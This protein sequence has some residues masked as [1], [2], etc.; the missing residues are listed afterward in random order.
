MNIITKIA[1]KIRGNVRNV[2]SYL[3]EH[4]KSKKYHSLNI[5]PLS[6][7]ISYTPKDAEQIFLSK[8]KEIYQNLPKRPNAISLV[9]SFSKQYEQTLYQ[10]GLD[11]KRCLNHIVNKLLE[12]ISEINTGNKYSLY[13]LK[14]IHKQTNNLHA[15]IVILTQSIQGNY[16][17]TTTL[18]LFQNNNTDYFKI[19]SQYANEYSKTLLQKP[20]QRLYNDSTL[21][22]QLKLIK[23]EKLIAEYGYIPRPIWIIKAQ[24]RLKQALQNVTAQPAKTYIAKQQSESIGIVQK[25]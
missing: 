18:K 19:I 12:K 25:I 13:A 15:H 5:T 7:L 9:V 11:P 17:K 23:E 20:P 8:S 2:V 6:N 1:S 14:G 24:K 4:S 16:I 22:N 3:D 10:K 21:I